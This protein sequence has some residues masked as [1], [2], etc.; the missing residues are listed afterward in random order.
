LRRSLR[1]ALG[2]LATGALFAATVLGVSAVDRALAMRMAELKVRG[3][4]ALEQFLGRRVDYGSI[5]PSVLRHI[6]V[7]DL[8][9]HSRDGSGGDLLTVRTLK[10]R[11]SLLGLLAS[12]DPV[13]A[14]REIR[15]SG[16][17]LRLDLDADRDLLDLV[18]RI[19]SS[20]ARTAALPASRLDSERA[21]SSMV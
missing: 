14:L 19:S 3:M 12:R 4:A 5:S 15:I 11:Y 17:A 1:F 8:V 20:G 18:S 7:R 10:V 13:G 2:F 6:V 9:V 16:A 21:P